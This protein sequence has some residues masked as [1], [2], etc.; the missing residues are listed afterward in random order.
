MNRISDHLY[1]FDDTCSVYAVV[2]GDATLLI[3]CGTHL[4]SSAIDAAGLPPVD[5]VLLTHFHRDQCAG[6]SNFKASG[7]EITVPYVEH[8]FFEETDLLKASYDTYDNYT[9]YYPTFGPLEDIIAD[10]YAYDYD[11]INWRGLS[12]EVIPLPGHTFGAVGYLFECDGNRVLACGDLLSSP[13]KMHEYF[14]SQWQYMDFKGHVNHMES[15]N[16]AASLDADL[17]LPG[18]GRPFACT[19]EAFS[20]LQ[21]PMEE[22]YE[23]FHD[24]K[25][26]YFKPEFRSVTEHVVEVSNAVRIGRNHGRTVSMAWYRLL[27]GAASRSNLVSSPDTF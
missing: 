10:R 13:G 11:R 2:N 4:N 3:D 8:R 6:S 23:L 20:T 9:A 22:L 19:A 27:H 21:E 17:I 14:W 7:A 24:R 25:Y 1:T 12:F 16:T 15:L 5:H 26:T 18:H